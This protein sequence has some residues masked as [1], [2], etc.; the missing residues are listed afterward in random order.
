MTR[1]RIRR[2][3]KGE[4]CNVVKN[5]E[6]NLEEIKKS[7]DYGD[8]YIN[9]DG[10]LIKDSEI[11]LAEKDKYVVSSIDKKFIGCGDRDWVN[12]CFKLDKKFKKEDK[13]SFPYWFSHWCAFQLVAL[14]L[15]VWRPRHLLHDIEKPWLKLVLPY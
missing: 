11:V 14:S 3:T 7:L 1:F 13:S 6:K 2:S 9:K 15:G 5:T 4:I 12:R 8:L 10:E